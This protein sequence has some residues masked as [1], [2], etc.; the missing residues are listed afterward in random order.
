MKW[1]YECEKCGATLD[2]GEHCDCESSQSDE[3]RRQDDETEARAE[4]NSNLPAMRQGVADQRSRRDTAR[5]IYLPRVRNIAEK[6]A[7]T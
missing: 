4:Q 2:A 3:G 5:R 7:I 6:G 1:P